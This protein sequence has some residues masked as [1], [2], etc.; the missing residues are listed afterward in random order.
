MDRRDNNF[1]VLRLIAAWMVLFSHSY[2][3]AGQA[4]ADPFARF[5]G[6]DTLGGVGVAIFFVLS[7]YL[8]T[9]SW[10]QSTSVLGFVWKRTRR[11]Y[12]ALVV[13]VLVS[14]WGVGPL[15]TTLDFMVYAAHDQTIGYL[16]TATAW[17]IR[18]VLP[19]LFWDNSYRHIF[20]GSLWSLPYEMACYLALIATG[21]LPL[22]LRW[23][24]L[25]VAVILVLMLL[26]RPLVPPASALDVVFGVDYY[27]VKLGLF[28]VTGACYQCWGEKVRP[29]WWIG[30]IGVVIA[31][32]LPDTSSRNL[33]W[34]FSLSTLLLGI[35]LG[36][37]WLPKLPSVM[38]DWSYGLY[39]YAFPVQQILS[40]HGVV[41]HLGFGGY[42]M[43]CTV[44]SLLCAALSWYAIERPMLRVAWPFSGLQR[45]LPKAATGSAT[46]E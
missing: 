2:P 26:V 32:A 37:S 20:N 24:G 33:L 5:A 19:G 14:T 13:C 36:V 34:I 28:F 23:K 12:P 18:Y 21:L 30:A 40:H 25:M 9:Q 44:L 4:I 3:L 43:L 1:D 29:V 8:V 17:D 22:A 7:G 38:G 39:L 27:T 15:L 10:R 46:R 42:T 16:L 31:W 45:P 6:I 35:A 11:I 41:K